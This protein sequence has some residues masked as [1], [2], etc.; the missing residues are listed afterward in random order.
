MAP[1]EIAGRGEISGDLHHEI[2]FA[3]NLI[4]PLRCPLAA[5]RLGAELLTRNDL[6]PAQSQRLARNVLASAARIEEILLDFAAQPESV[7]PSELL[8]NPKKIPEIREHTRAGGCELTTD[9][10][11]T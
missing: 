4:V 5:V 10:I 3:H 6:S 8:H 7:S 1:A 11:G 9:R 2:S